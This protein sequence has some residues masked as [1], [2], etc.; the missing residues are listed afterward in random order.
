MDAAR[1]TM[2]VFVGCLLPGMAMAGTQGRCSN[3]A[4][5]FVSLSFH[6]ATEIYALQNANNSIVQREAGP[7]FISSGALLL[8]GAS[9]LLLLLGSVILSG[10]LARDG[11]RYGISQVLSK[12]VENEGGKWE[13]LRSEVMKSWV[14]ARTWKTWLLYYQLSV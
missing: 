3:I 14:A 10:K 4:A 8:L 12:D 1:L 11:V 9:S 13:K 6:I 5:L 7:W 2:C